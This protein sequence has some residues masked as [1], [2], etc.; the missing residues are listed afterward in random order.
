MLTHTTS[1]TLV[2]M[3]DPALY[4]PRDR[5]RNGRASVALSLRRAPGLDDRRTAHAT[6]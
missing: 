6:K 4:V 5:G 3:P 2:L 1:E